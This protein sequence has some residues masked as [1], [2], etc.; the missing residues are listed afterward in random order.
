[1]NY[2]ITVDGIEKESGT[3]IVRQEIINQYIKQYNFVGTA[4]EPELWE[5]KFLTEREY[6]KFQRRPFSKK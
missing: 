6:R 4:V 1:M 5:Y 2:K 3:G